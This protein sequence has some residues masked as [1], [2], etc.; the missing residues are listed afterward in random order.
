MDCRA[1]TQVG[2]DFGRKLFQLRKTRS[3]GATP[4]IPF[5]AIRDSGVLQTDDPLSKRCKNVIACLSH[6]EHRM[7]MKLRWTAR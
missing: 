7:W 2:P 4:S 5:G 1:N 6:V 3:I